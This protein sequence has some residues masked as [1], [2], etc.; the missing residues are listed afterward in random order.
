LHRVPHELPRSHRW[1]S[2]LVRFRPPLCQL[3][4]WSRIGRLAVKRCSVPS[5]RSS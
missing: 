4:G 2:P 5:G 3:R 1:R